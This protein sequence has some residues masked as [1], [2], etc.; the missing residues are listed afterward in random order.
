MN[1]LAKRAQIKLASD[2]VNLL[3]GKREALLKELIERAR[4]LRALRQELQTRGVMSAQ[5]AALARAVRGTPEVR[6]AGVAGRRELSLG[7]KTEKVWGLNLGSIEQTNIVRDPAERAIGHL[8]VS[9]HIFEAA[10]DAERMLQQLI[11]C[12]PAERNLMLIGEEVRKVSRRINA[13]EE[14]L[15]PRLREEVRNIYRVLDERERE[16]TFR[17]KRI[18]KKQGQEAKQ[19]H[20]QAGQAEEG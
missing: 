12:A 6:S 14:Y 13:L 18:K 2:G 15:L 7:V 3:K 8:D 19:D 16:D 4:K 9:S 20:Q 17:L 5:S 1:L 10:E 11:E